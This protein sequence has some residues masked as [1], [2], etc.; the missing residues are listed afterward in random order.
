[1]ATLSYT[2]TSSYTGADTLN[3]SDE[4]TADALTATGHVSITVNSTASSDTTILSNHPS[5]FVY[6]QT[7]IFS[8]TING[9]SAG[10]PTGSVQFEI[11]N[12]AQGSPVALVAGRASFT[13][14]AFTA[15][16]HTITAVYTSTN[17]KIASGQA[18]VTETVQPAL[19][20][21]TAANESKVYGAAL[22]ALAV[23]YS[24]FQN[25][26]TVAS[27]TTKATASTTATAS[28]NV[29]T[30]T[31]TASGATDPNYVFR[32][33]SGVL[34]VTPAPLTITA[35]SQSKVAGSANPALTFAATGYVNGNTASSLTT[36]PKLST[37][38]TT[39]SAA[40]SYPITASGAVDA[41]YTIKYVSG[42]LS[43]TAAP[44]ASAVH[45][46][47]VVTPSVTSS[48]ITSPVTSAVH[49]PVT[50]SVSNSGQVV[51]AL[52][53]GTQETTTTTSAA[54]AA[55]S[56]VSNAGLSV[57]MA[58]SATPTVSAK[59]SVTGLPSPGVSQAGSQTTQK[60][61]F[62]TAILDF[63]LA[64]LFI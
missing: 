38:A 27:L 6:G 9:G 39:T 17:S 8:A 30:Y 50:S 26:D 15:G 58:T 59:A 16:M 49:A 3:L 44:V 45:A 57:I 41:N 29:G 25:S 18:S 43:V 14:S 47:A 21:V 64:D 5:G 36:Q 35:N 61:V 51:T 56:V 37:T 2:P 34:T 63:D 42:T 20:T 46:A 13:T 19:V 48:V 54:S 7:V 55:K 31:I 12:V 52:A 1:M 60:K 28:S 40:G 23:S 11:D 10:T 53:L 4:D 33:L 22:P 24:G 62:E 32:Y